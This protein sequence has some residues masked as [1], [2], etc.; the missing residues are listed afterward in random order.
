MSQMVINEPIEATLIEIDQVYSSR[1]FSKIP[2]IST[3][4][5]IKQ[6]RGFAPI[7]ITDD[8]M[9]IQ[10]HDI[11]EAYRQMEAEIVPCIFQR[12]IYQAIENQRRCPWN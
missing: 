5:E 4:K 12:Q 9:V 2:M 11:L 6:Q 1:D 10:G 7:I 3:I 8:Y